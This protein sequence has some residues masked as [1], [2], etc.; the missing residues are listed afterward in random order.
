MAKKRLGVVGTFVWDVIHG[1]DV[2][3][4]PIEEWGGRP[5]R[6]Q[7]Q[8]RTTCSITDADGPPT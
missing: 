4:A 1:R 7:T 5:S 6:S 2:R 8:S 3:T